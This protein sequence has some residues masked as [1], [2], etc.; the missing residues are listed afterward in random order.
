MGVDRTFQPYRRKVANPPIAGHRSGFKRVAS[1][2]K[3]PESDER[4]EGAKMGEDHY[5]SDKEAEVPHPIH[6][7]RLLRGSHGARFI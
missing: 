5:D 1:P 3:I 2:W 6:D 7:E 4:L